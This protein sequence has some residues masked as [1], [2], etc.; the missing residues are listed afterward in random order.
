[1]VYIG[2]RERMP[3][4]VAGLGSFEEVSLDDLLVGRAG[5]CGELSV[6]L[7]V[8]LQRQQVCGTRPGIRVHV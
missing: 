5:F 6:D 1:M 7:D 3:E 2:K 8:S 4:A